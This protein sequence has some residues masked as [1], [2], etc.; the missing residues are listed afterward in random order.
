[1]F[2]DVLGGYVTGENNRRTRRRHI[3]LLIR[4]KAVHF[5]RSR[6]DID[7]HTKIEAARTLQ[8]VPDQKGNL[9]RSEAIDEDLRRRDDE[10]IRHRWIGYR[11]T[12][13]PFRSVNQEGLAHHYAQRSCT[14]SNGLAGCGRGCG[15]GLRGGRVLPVLSGSVLR[16]SRA[17]SGRGRTQK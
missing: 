2:G 15:G 11:D 7:I 3:D 1:M 9:A 4:E 6:G 12:L 5:F 14:R 16:E 8:F 17:N 13:Q 10:R